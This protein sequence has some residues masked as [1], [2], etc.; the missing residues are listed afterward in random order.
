ME[1][2]LPASPLEEQAQEQQENNSEQKIEQASQEVSPRLEDS[3]D[4]DIDDDDAPTVPGLP[5][6]GRVPRSVTPEVTSPA[7]KEEPD[8]ASSTNV[9]EKAVAASE[10]HSQPEPQAEVSALPADTEE[11]QAASASAPEEQS[12]PAEPKATPVIAPVRRPRAETF[13]STRQQR[14]VRAFEKRQSRKQP[15]TTNTEPKGT[16]PA[17]QPQNDPS[18]PDIADAPTRELTTPEASAKPANPPKPAMPVSVPRR[19]G[20]DASS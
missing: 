8:A 3:E 7:H 4:S 6:I 20:A 5:A 17:E 15:A 10:E 9:N 13:I 18:S 1:Q 16:S 12:G 19:P 14:A 2:G 11:P